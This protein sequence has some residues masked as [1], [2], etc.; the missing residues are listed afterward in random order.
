[1]NVTRENVD[2]LNAILKITVEKNDYQA[3]VDKTLE[4]YRKRSNIP[5]FRKGKVPMG[6]IKKQY[7]KAV[8]GDELNRVVSDALYKYIE[9]E[10]IEVLGNP[11]P[12]NDIEIKG[13][14]DNPDT[15]E[16]AYEIG[17][18]PVVDV[19]LSGR[20]KFDFTKVKVDDALIDKQVDDL[21]RRYGKLVSVDKVGE[22]DLILCQ[23]V[24]LDEAGEIKVGGIM[25]NST[26]SM[27]FVEDK[28]TAKEIIGKKVGDKVVV[29]PSKVSKGG[30]DTAAMLGITEE[31]LANVADKFQMT[32][33]EIK[34][35]EPAEMNQE[36]FDKLFGEGAVTS[37]KELREKVKEDLVKMF[38]NDSNRI[39]VRRI[40]NSLIEKTEFE[41]PNEF[42]K[43]WIFVT[44]NSKHNHDHDHGHDHQHN[45]V[46]MEDIERDYENY[47]RG[48][49]WQLIQGE[50]FK[51]NDLKIE[52]QEAI[53]YTKGLLVNQYAQYGISAPEDKE[54]E[55]SAIQVLKDNKEAQ[56]I[57]DMLADE[58]ML[59]YFKETV[60][61]V[62]V[63]VDY[64]EFLRIAQ[65]Q[66]A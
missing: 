59:N 20:N 8:L 31:E 7:G 5:G 10:K 58:K 39:L 65:D 48:L 62:D 16:F 18:S 4:D 66:N 49:R 15:F 25:N 32:I 11:L 26:I 24:E 19:K 47:V 33:N 36:L 63:E 34:V 44:Q 1:M 14:F 21:T 46:S 22:K 54:L 40:S 61:L 37:E 28:K 51:K 64:D 56:Q 13:D 35:M 2:E 3:K 60:K 6:M 53:E 9:D 57:Y 52:R 23:F 45:H 30:K 12:K 42:L 55:A 17:I 50:I 38:E 29:D 27:E 43:R 41:L